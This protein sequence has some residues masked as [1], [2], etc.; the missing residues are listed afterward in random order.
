M[1]LSKP[2]RAQRPARNIFDGILKEPAFSPDALPSRGND[3]TVRV[4]VG[5]IEG[6]SD[7]STLYQLPRKGNHLNEN[8]AVQSKND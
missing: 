7:G 5:G 2:G 8:T 3:S 6:N 4:A 1:T